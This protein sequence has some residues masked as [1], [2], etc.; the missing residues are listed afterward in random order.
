MIAPGMAKM[1]SALERE[2]ELRAL[3]KLTEECWGIS[4]LAM[5]LRDVGGPIPEACLRAREKR[6]R[7]AAKRL[8]LMQAR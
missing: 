3:R 1:V 7:R 6:A 4:L 2:A 5:G 8:R